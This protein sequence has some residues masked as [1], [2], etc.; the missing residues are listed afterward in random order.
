MRGSSIFALDDT[1]LL[2]P[3]PERLVRVSPF[4]LDRN[5]MT[6]REMRTLVTGGLVARPFARGLGRPACT[7]TD[8]PDQLEDF[9]VNCIAQSNAARACEARGAR[10][11]TEAEWEFA[12]GDRDEEKRYPWGADPDACRFACRR[13]YPGAASAAGC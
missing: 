6:V 12:A 1:T 10:L 3:V 8:A 11:P 5:E 9:P 13:R 4:A 2:S 7:W